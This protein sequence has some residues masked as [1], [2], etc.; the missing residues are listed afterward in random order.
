MRSFCRD[1]LSLKLVTEDMK[2]VLGDKNR[3]LLHAGTARHFILHGVCLCSC[4]GFVRTWWCGPC[5]RAVLDFPSTRPR[6]WEP[7][8]SSML[9]NHVMENVMRTIA[10]VGFCSHV[11]RRSGQGWHNYQHPD[12]FVWIEVAAYWFSRRKTVLM[13]SLPK[14]LIFHV[15][16]MPSSFFFCCFKTSLMVFIFMMS[17]A[18]LSPNVCRFGI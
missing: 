17:F 18:V 9:P 2:A 15:L 12:V 7:L 1:C 13:I 4:L 16:W 11:W 6:K 10:F 5:M 3:S 14:N 8:D